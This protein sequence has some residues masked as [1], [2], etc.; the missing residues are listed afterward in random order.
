MDGDLYGKGAPTNSSQ[1]SRSGVVFASPTQIPAMSSDFDFDL[2]SINKDGNPTGRSL[3][4]FQVAALKGYTVPNLEMYGCPC[5]PNCDQLCC[6]TKQ[7]SVAPLN[8]SSHQLHDDTL[9][10]SP[11][12]TSSNPRSTSPTGSYE[13]VDSTEEFIPKMHKLV[14]VCVCVYVCT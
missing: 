6:K 4:G 11:V 14:S 5:N 3:P 10:V 13:S 12:D 1:S 9:L 8:I 2:N 7:K